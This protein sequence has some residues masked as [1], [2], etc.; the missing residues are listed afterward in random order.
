MT[1]PSL[2]RRLGAAAAVIGVAALVSGPGASAGQQSAPAITATGAGKVKIG[3]S[4]AVLRKRG[5]IGRI[6][7]GCEL[8][9]PNT[10]AATL[11]SP[12]RGSVNFTL[13]SPRR[14]TD[15]LITGG[16]AAARG[17]GIGDTLADIQAAYP[18]A[19]VDH[20]TD[21]VFEFT[22]VKIPK[23]DGGKL[24]FA[25]STKTDK[26]TAIGVPYIAVCE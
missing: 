18:S 10:R 14:V 9:G 24:Q 12:L 23:S 4:Y 6:R 13:K 21:E 7:H 11:K 25:V 2:S 19:K 17:V 16:D 15:I 8:G 20:G 5:A 1:L 3:N 22:L 26:I